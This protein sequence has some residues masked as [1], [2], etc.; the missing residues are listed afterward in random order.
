MGMAGVPVQGVLTGTAVVTVTGHAAPAWA[1]MG[2]LGAVGTIS[3][4]ASVTGTCTATVTTAITMVGNVRARV[5]SNGLGRERWIKLWLR[6][7]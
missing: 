2:Y 3:V 4:M 1:V 7:V 6:G 5:A